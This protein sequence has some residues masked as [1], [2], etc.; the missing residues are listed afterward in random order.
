M[1]TNKPLSS[2]KVDFNTPL[3][4]NAFKVDFV[5]YN[6]N[7]DLKSDTS[8]SILGEYGSRTVNSKSKRSLSSSHSLKMRKANILLTA[9]KPRSFKITL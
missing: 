7:S 1:K 2:F 3:P 9:E 6:S 5:D 4:Q 8:A